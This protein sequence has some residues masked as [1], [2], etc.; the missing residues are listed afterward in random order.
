MSSWRLDAPDPA[1]FL[2]KFDHSFRGDL[3]QTIL[4]K[5][6]PNRNDDLE[7]V[8]INFIFSES[9]RSCSVMHESVVQTLHIPPSFKYALVDGA[10][11]Q[12]LS[13]NLKEGG[14]RESCKEKGQE[15]QQT[16]ERWSSRSHQCMRPRCSKAECKEDS[17]CYGYP[18]NHNL[19]TFPPKDIHVPITVKSFTKR[20]QVSFSSTKWNR[21]WK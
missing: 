8:I 18:T 21:D 13:A 9:R 11:L 14:N 3:N 7:L 17:R 15:L 16:Q 2:S 12:R 20:K 4:L 19:G 1:R 10:L 6:G 5:Y